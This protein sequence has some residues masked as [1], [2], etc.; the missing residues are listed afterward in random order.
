M[1]RSKKKKANRL[2]R[3]S[4][5]LSTAC[6][7]ATALGPHS[8]AAVKQEQEKPKA[9]PF[10]PDLIKSNIDVALAAPRTELSMPGRYPGRVAE[11]YHSKAVVGNKP[12]QGAAA[13]MLAAGMQSL[14]GKTDYRESWSQLFS[15]SDRIGI[16]INPTGRQLLSNT[17][18]LTGA[19]IAS[20]EAVGVPRKNIVIWDRCGDEA[21][22]A[23]YVNERYPGIEMF[24]TE[25]IEEEDGQTVRKGVEN[26]DK[27]VFY[28][29]DIDQP[30]DERAKRY[31]I[32]GGTKSF[33]TNILTQGVDK[34]INV[35]VLKN[36]RDSVTL[37]LKNMAHGA[38][39]NT[40]RGHRIWHRYIAE[41]CAFP[42]VRDKTVLNI[43]D[44]LRGCYEGG[45]VGL[46]RYVWNAN[47]I[48]VSTDPV[49]GDRIAWETIFAK[50]V[51]EG[52]ATEA[53]RENMD[54]MLNQLVRAEKFRLGIYDRGNIEHNRHVVG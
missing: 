1:T 32:H 25:Y 26:L 2:S 10:D 5:L 46:A 17:H 43:I 13:I 49:A 33:F 11:V 29:F 12:D 35:P 39:S 51:V 40:A 21:P 44:G 15:P 41:V 9:E 27:N 50:R 30:Y 22:D 45:P 8:M 16:K 36:Y 6:L 20:L 42:A 4:F 24:W 19:I 34:V 53:D 52:V 18:E 28:E 14:T 47:A 37:C 48:W 3:R 23:G 31:T 54:T 38:T 7:G